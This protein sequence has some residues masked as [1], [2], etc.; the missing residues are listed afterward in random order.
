MVEVTVVGM[1]V[2][3]VVGIDEHVW[4][5]GEVGVGSDGKGPRLD[6][7]LVTGY[8]SFLRASLHSY[9]LLQRNRNSSLRIGSHSFDLRGCDVLSTARGA[10][11]MLTR[12]N[13]TPYLQALISAAQYD[14]MSAS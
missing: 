11:H 12:S 8:V 10:D 6:L 14:F 5:G 2:E 7:G 4:G 9:T 3:V 1:A 13:P